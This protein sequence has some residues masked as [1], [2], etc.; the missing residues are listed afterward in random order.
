MLPRPYSKCE[1]EWDSEIYNVIDRSDFVYTRKLCFI[2]CYQDYVIKKYN[3]TYPDLLSLFSHASECDLDMARFNYTHDSFTTEFINTFCLS[4]CPLEC[5][6]TLFKTIMSS[7][8]INVN[9]FMN[10]SYYYISSIRDNP[11]LAGDFI[12]RKIDA[13]QAR[14][15]IV[16]MNIFYD[17]LS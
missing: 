10:G 9:Y 4:L 6:Q 12:Y 16:E 17:S 13:S 1:V 8:Q 15:S 11:R 14:E 3:C 7:T 2:Q 5:N